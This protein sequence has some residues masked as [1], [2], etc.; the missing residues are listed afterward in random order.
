[1]S[2]TAEMLASEERFTEFR[3]TK[4]EG[5]DV[6]RSPRHLKTNELAFLASDALEDLYGQG[7][8]ERLAAFAS[9]ANCEMTGAFSVP[10]GEFNDLDNMAKGRRR[11][12]APGRMGLE[13]EDGK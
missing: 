2:R 8:S 13:I 12:S 10:D 6:Y 9:L 1:L 7:C 3:E 5:G 11:G 4:A